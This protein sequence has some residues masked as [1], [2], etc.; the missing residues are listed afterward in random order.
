MLGVL[1]CFVQLLILHQHD[2]DCQ[3]KEEERADDYAQDEVHYN[4]PGSV[5]ILVNIH[6]LGP[7]FHGDALKDSQ[8]G[9]ANVVEVREA[10]VQLVDV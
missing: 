8:E 2:S 9:G 5:S 6:D 4:E 7:T 1:R 10:I 3:I